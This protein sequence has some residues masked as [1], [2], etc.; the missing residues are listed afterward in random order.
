MRIYDVGR[1]SNGTPTYEAHFP[2]AMHGC[3]LRRQLLG[4]N[5]YS[6]ANLQIS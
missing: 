5:A 4:A 2:D 1:P 6:E 3:L